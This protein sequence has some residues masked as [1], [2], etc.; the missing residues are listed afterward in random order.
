[1]PPRDGPVLFRSRSL[2]C[3]GP[4]PHATASGVSVA[5]VR[6]PLGCKAGPGSFHVRAWISTPRVRDHPCTRKRRIWF[7]LFSSHGEYCGWQSQRMR[8]APGLQGFHRIQGAFGAGEGTVGPR[9]GRYAYKYLTTVCATAPQKRGITAES[10]GPASPCFRPSN[11][12]LQ[13]DDGRARPGSQDFPSFHVQTVARLLVLVARFQM[14][15]HLQMVL[16]GMDS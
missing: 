4:R 14:M 10:S 7:L 13:S 8:G 9:D 16:V 3:L 11:S 15:F 1:M 2:S 12:L 6:L 5:L